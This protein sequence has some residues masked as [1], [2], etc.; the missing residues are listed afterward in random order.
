MNSIEIRNA[1]EIKAITNLPGATT[2]VGVS[3]AGLSTRMKNSI[4]S[5]TKAYQTDLTL[6]KGG[7]YSK[8]KEL[9]RYLRQYCGIPRT[10][11]DGYHMKVVN[12]NEE[13]WAQAVD[14]IKTD[15]MAARLTADNKY[16][17]DRLSS[18]LEELELCNDE[19][20]FYHVYQDRETMPQMVRPFQLQLAQ[21]Y[22]KQYAEQYQQ[23]QDIVTYGG[24]IHF[25]YIR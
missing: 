19:R 7:Y 21:Q 12:L 25:E 13:Q 23:M 3:F 11:F 20:T 22:Q 16:Q 1:W 8:A 18:I 14:L 5:H 2:S 9:S 17:I 24:T 15:T 4:M 6:G 10:V